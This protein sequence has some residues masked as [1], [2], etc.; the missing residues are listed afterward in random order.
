MKKFTLKEKLKITNRIIFIFLVF[1]LSS[2]SNAQVQNNDIFYI[3]NGGS[4]FVGSGSYTF[5]ASSG[6]TL[7]TRTASTYGKLSFSPTA[8]VAGVADTHYLNGYA[9]VLRTTP[10]LLPIGQS[11]EYAPARI[12]PTTVAPVDA[13]Y[14]RAN[15]TTVGATLDATVPA[16]SSVEYWNIQGANNAVVTLTWRVSSNLSAIASATAT[17][18]IVGY[19]G[20]KWVKIPS[21]VDATSILG[22]AST[23]SSG[24]VTSTA[25]VNLNTYKYFSI[26]A[27]ASL[28]TPQFNSGIATIYVKNNE[29]VVKSIDEMT[30]VTLYDLTGKRVFESKID[31]ATQFYAPINLANAIYIARVQ[32]SN[33][34]FAVKKLINNN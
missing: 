29:L 14:Y 18:F 22:G 7:T 31:N 5:G 2:T 4:V 34:T 8:T 25:A 3:G 11:G 6:Q 28:S 19:D 26:G 9:S 13:A 33:D 12:T 16:I 15:P 10:F 20:T 17:L 32:Y 21:A 1:G 30:S 27:D 24:S 23:I